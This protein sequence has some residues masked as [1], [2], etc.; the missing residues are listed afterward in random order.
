MRLHYSSPLLFLLI[1]SKISFSWFTKCHP[2]S[3]CFAF[4]SLT[5]SSLSVFPIQFTL[6]YSSHSL[7]SYSSHSLFSH[8]SLLNP[9]SLVPLFTLFTLARNWNVP[10]FTVCDSLAWGLCISLGIFMSR[11]QKEKMP[12]WWFRIHIV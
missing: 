5:L 8:S 9:C 4:Y 11:F 7:H 1:L 2:F 12:V 6:F 10:C 3:P